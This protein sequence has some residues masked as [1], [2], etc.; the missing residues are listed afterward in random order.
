[1][2]TILAFVVV[3]SLLVFIHEL[4]H[5]LFAKRAGILV[6]E[7]AIGFGPRLISWF[8][9][10][11][12]YSLRLLP[13]GGYVR[14]AGE[15]PEIVELKTGTYL[16]LDQDEQGRVVRIRTPK[17]D[18]QA[19]GDVM[20]MEAHDGMAGG[21]LP[22]HLPRPVK[23]V[24]GKLLEAD[25]EEKLFILLETGEGEEERYSLHPQALIQY[26]E[27]NKIQIAP[28]DRQFGSK[29]VG[30]RALAILAGPVFN[31]VLAVIL[32]ATL[33]KMY[34]LETHVSI[35]GVQPNTP[36]QE[37]GI[38]QG[39]IIQRVNG[40]E[41]KTL[42]SV[43]M[44][45]QEAQGK[46]VEMQLTRDGQPYTVKVKPAKNEQGQYMIGIQMHQ[47]K[48]AASIM[49]SITDGFHET[50]VW[51]VRIFDGFAQLL[52]GKIG[53][54]SL[55]GPVRIAS[56]TGE[57]AQAGY[58]ALIQWTA[59]LSLYLGVFNLLPFP[60]LDGSRLAFILFEGLRGRPIDPNKESMVHFVGFA[61]L[62]LLMVVVTYN[63]ILK[64]FFS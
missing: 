18:A 20:G 11:T 23:T 31:I 52:T 33:T 21:D 53:L 57:A 43:G 45:V 47:D 17:P 37:A 64:V 22:D 29:T 59:V 40:E 56:M 26:D 63:D 25:L 51:T 14:M 35:Q 19:D 38:K 28:L 12:Q 32:F 48:R 15:D 44:K 24:G 30:E 8:R 2:Q 13:L 5:F 4:G 1:M 50:Y 46:P 60:A 62:M 61:L 6:R 10:E 58:L 39:D 16:L 42:A 54:E 55:G 49:E 27:K 7:F 36:A 34:G 3:L 41:T 9:G